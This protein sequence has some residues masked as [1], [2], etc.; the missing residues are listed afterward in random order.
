[1]KSLRPLYM[2]SLFLVLSFC[3]NQSTTNNLSL[4]ECINNVLSPTDYEKFI[5]EE[6]TLEPYQDLIDS[7][8]SGELV[9]TDSAVVE[10]EEEALEITTS[11]TEIIKVPDSIKGFTSE[12]LNSSEKWPMIYAFSNISDSSE[13]H[14]IAKTTVSIQASRLEKI[15]MVFNSCESNEITL[16]KIDTNQNEDI[17]FINKNCTKGTTINSFKYLE[18]SNLNFILRLF[19]EG[20]Y[21]NVS[22]G[23]K[24]C[25]HNVNLKEFMSKYLAYINTFFA[26]TT[27]TT[28]TIPYPPNVSIGDC[29]ET[30]ENNISFSI[31]FTLN[32]PSSKITSIRVKTFLNGDVESEIFFENNPAIELTPKDSSS[33]YVYDVFIPNRDNLTS[34]IIEIYARNER[35]QETTGQCDFNI[36]VPDRSAPGPFGDVVLAPREMDVYDGYYRYFSATTQLRNSDKIKRY[37]YKLISNEFGSILH[38]CEVVYSNGRQLETN[39]ELLCSNRMRLFS[40]EFPSYVNY[41]AKDDPG[42]SDK[43][44]G[45]YRLE[46]E[47]EDM[48]GNV[49]KF[50]SCKAL[51][52]YSIWS[53]YPSSSMKAVNES[54]ESCG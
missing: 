36:F 7:C 45:W 25:C 33:G 49:G 51:R 12:A 4:N 46:L 6:I 38:T 5:N 2:M 22:T 16:S 47:V 50:K 31:P 26:T 24:G 8:L 52:V 19:K 32:A 20:D 15:K 40:S 14:K 17:E 53:F 39:Y 34:G 1:M 44:V 42:L 48:A 18:L 13:S 27:T 9:F 28:T 11:T 35:G 10:Q 43:N 21:E 29:P 37:T 41:S 30:T 3:S 54:Y 23:E